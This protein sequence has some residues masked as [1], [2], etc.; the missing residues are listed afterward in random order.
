MFNLYQVCCDMKLCSG[1]F[2]FPTKLLIAMHLPS[3]I[4]IKNKRK[5]L[6]DGARTNFDIWHIRCRCLTF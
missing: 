3:T 4:Q 2:V 1:I 5:S 6:S